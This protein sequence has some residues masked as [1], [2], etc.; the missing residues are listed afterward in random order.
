MCFYVEIYAYV[1]PQRLLLIASESIDF[2]YYITVR[3]PWL[4]DSL[5]D[6]RKYQY[7]SHT[8]V[9]VTHVALI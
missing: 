8:H 4:D 7:A 1:I 5:T 3:G 9:C 2:H 6:R